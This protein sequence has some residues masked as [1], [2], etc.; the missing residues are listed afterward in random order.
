MPRNRNCKKEIPPYDRV[1]AYMANKEY[2]MPKMP[3]F[4]RTV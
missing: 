3:W 1:S 4:R 2:N